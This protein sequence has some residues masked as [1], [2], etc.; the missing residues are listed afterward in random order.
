VLVIAGKAEL[1]RGSYS[2]AHAQF[3]IN[4]PKTA[5]NQQAENFI[6]SE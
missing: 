2:R 3:L 1:Q 5:Q 6:H 4:Q